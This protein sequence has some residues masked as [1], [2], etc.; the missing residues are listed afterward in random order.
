IVRLKD[1]PVTKNGKMDYAALPAPDLQLD[2]TDHVERHTA[3]EEMLCDLW[4]DVLRR[5]RVSVHGDFFELGG[6]SLLVMLLVS[7]I[8]DVFGVEIPLGSVFDHPTVAKLALVI[9]D[10]LEGG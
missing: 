3:F 10:T 7:R 2:G 4:C 5:E 1:L 9:E 6:H 8:R